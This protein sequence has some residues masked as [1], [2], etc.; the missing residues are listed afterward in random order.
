MTKEPNQTEQL[1]KTIKLDIANH[2]GLDY[3]F[4]AYQKGKLSK[5]KLCELIGDLVAECELHRERLVYKKGQED[6]LENISANPEAWT[7][8]RLAVLRER[9]RMYDVIYKEHVKNMPQYAELTSEIKKLE[10]K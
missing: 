7:V 9:K 3:S 2:I 1:A 6:L 4:F 5:R 8:T 10:G